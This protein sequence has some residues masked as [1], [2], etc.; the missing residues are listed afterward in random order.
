MSSDKNGMANI[1]KEYMDFG[2]LQVGTFLGS[3]HCKPVEESFDGI[4]VVK[5]S[6]TKYRFVV[7]D[8]AVNTFMED[9]E[10]M[11]YE[12]V[13][14][15][16]KL[17]KANHTVD[18][19]N[20]WI[21]DNRKPSTYRHLNPLIAFASIELDFEKDTIH[22]YRSGDCEVFVETEYGWHK[23]HG[24]FL[25]YHGRLLASNLMKAHEETYGKYQEM[26]KWWEVQT[27]QLDDVSLFS[28]PTLGL[29]E[30]FESH[31]YV[32]ELSEIKRIVLTSDGARLTRSI[33]K[34]TNLDEYMFHHIHGHD[35]QHGDLSVID[36]RLH[37]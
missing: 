5:I 20:K 2:N 4:E 7:M 36:V 27:V 9:A 12:G 1:V 14:S 6:D 32:R 11:N 10:R 19:A 33:L 30:K 24:D 18:A 17:L 26:Q 22:I 16:K 13:D 37:V 15:F 3:L 28:Y 25:T 8:A 23:T 21:E 31:V 29:T 35:C 34:G